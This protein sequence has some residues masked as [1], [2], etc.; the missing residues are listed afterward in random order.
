M[1]PECNPEKVPMESGRWRTEREREGDK[2]ANRRT[3]MIQ[4]P[5][6]IWG[7]RSERWTGK[8]T[9]GHPSSEREIEKDQI[10]E[11]IS[12]DVSHQILYNVNS[13]LTGFHQNSCK[14]YVPLS[15]IDSK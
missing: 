9:E 10:S 6:E 12:L 8:Q 4:V 1:R 5:R 3:M 2:W 13:A 15:G 7:W 11:Y 14:D